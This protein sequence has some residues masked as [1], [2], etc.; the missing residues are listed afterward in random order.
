MGGCHLANDARS[1]TTEAI[2]NGSAPGVSTRSSRRVGKY[3]D[4]DELSQM[5]SNPTMFGCPRIYSIP[6]AGRD[7]TSWSSDVHFV[8][9]EEWSE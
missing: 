8:V 6:A 7:R 1:L 4:T 5:P 9:N 2:D 3:S